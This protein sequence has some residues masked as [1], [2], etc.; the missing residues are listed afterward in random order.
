MPDIKDQRK[1]TSS[2]AFTFG[3]TAINW[4][5]RL[6]TIIVLSTAKTKLTVV[7]D[8]AKETLYLKLLLCDLGFVYDG[9]VVSCSRSAIHLAENLAFDSRMK[10]IEVSFFL[11]Q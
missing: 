3:G 9:I 6:Q 7:A 10:H 11:S 4:R 1:L 8:A 2:Y 5:A